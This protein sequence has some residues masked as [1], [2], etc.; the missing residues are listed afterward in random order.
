MAVLQ[1]N[2]EVYGKEPHRSM[3]VLPQPIGR[4]RHSLW[5]WGSQ[6]EG[7][8]VPVLRDA[9]W[10]V[11]P[12]LWMSACLPVA[13]SWVTPNTPAYCEITISVRL[14][15]LSRWWQNVTLVLK[16]WQ[17]DTFNVYQWC[18]GEVKATG[19]ERKTDFFKSFF[20]QKNWGVWVFHL[21]GYWESVY[22]MSGK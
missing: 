9:W 2:P 8:G 13:S 19:C 6:L 22:F 18:R 3:G 12:E 4:W 7:F 1:Q 5:H 11:Q 10:S 16:Q 17:G 21:F 20:S 14:Q 15:E